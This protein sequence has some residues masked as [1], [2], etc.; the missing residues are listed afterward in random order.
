MKQNFNKS[1]DLL[2]RTEGGFQDDP[3][4][5]GNRLP[6]G[7]KGCTNLGVTQLAWE[8]Y[9]GRK[10]DHDEMRQLT[11]EDVGPFYKRLYW[12]SIGAD[13]LP[14]GV[15]YA[16][17]DISVNLGSHR[18]I[19]IRNHAMEQTDDPSQLIEFICQQRLELMRSF[20]SYPRYKHGWETRV[21][22][23]EQTAQDMVS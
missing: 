19:E 15:D 13:N 4:D 23:V 16:L 12:D 2:L 3:H 9:V 8:S 14:S 21:A 6:D 18:A 7:R 1:F 22:A 20:S 11:S 5:H 17:F 10:V